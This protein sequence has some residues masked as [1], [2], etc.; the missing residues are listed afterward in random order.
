MLLLLPLV[1]K[2]NEA[3]IVFI[4]IVVSKNKDCSLCWY[5]FYNELF[6]VS[7]VKDG[8]VYWK[9]GLDMN[10]YREF[11]ISHGSL[12]GFVVMKYTYVCFVTIYYVLVSLDIVSLM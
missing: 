1:C 11:E 9:K 12:V 8:K 5:G 10:W 3:H 2:V 7:H 4:L 6:C